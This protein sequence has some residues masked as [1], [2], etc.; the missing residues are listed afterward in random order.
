MTPTFKALAASTFL[1]FF[2]V[3]CDDAKKA[4]GA[5]DSGAEEGGGG[6]GEGL[7]YDVDDA[8]GDTI[9]DIHEGDE[10]TDGDGDANKND[11][12]SD[13]DS[14]KDRI[15]AGDGDP[16]TLPVDS[17]GDGNP[18]Y[19]DLD[20]DNNCVTDSDEKRPTGDGPVD[21]DLDGVRDYADEDNDGDGILDVDEIGGSCA[22]PDTDGDGTQDYMDLDSDGDGIGDLAEGGTTAFD[23]DP[24]DTDGDGVADYLDEDSD[25]DGVSDNAEGGGADVP[26]DTDGDGVPDFQDTDSDGDSISDYE[27]LN[28][29]GTDPYDADSDGDGFSDGG[30]LAAGT[31][32]LDSASVVEGVYVEVPERTNIEELF[33]FTLQVQLGDIA[34]LID[35]T[36]SMGSTANAMATEF[37]S[38]VSALTSTIPDAQYAVGTYDDYAYGGFGSAGSRDKP[39]YMLQQVTDD[40][41]TVQTTLSSRVQ[42]HGGSDGPESSMEALYQGATGEGY[43]QDCNRSYA[44]T[45]DVLPF[46]ASSTDPFGG[47]AG[48]HWV[49]SS[50][51]GGLNGGFGFRDY[52]LP[53]MVYATDYDLRD[54]DAGYGTPGGCPQ[55]AGKSD[56]VAAFADLQAYAIGIH[57]NS[58]T[59]TPYNQMLDLAAATGSYADT[60]GDGS[61]DDP[62][63][64]RWSG[65]SSTFRTTI[66]G[67]IEDLV[68]SIRFARVNLLIEGDEWG[69]VTGVS[70][71]YFTDID[72]AGGTQEIEF[73]LSFRGVVAAT[74]EDQLYRLSLTVVGDDS[75]LLDTLDII[76]LVP[77][78]SY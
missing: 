45:T 41:S 32:P 43:D 31:D 39:F 69:F 4:A 38:I 24:V 6:G 76:V 40:V 23:S 51:G 54:P 65:S 73:T 3:G 70:P 5:D 58:Y 46:L 8:D 68:S 50:S 29:T 44:S 71:E 9:I 14:I 78:N 36:C 61:S 60:D 34:F 63:A 26:R 19:L 15:E 74:T 48:Q 1:T 62:L 13:G 10:D 56:V 47:G 21:T 52:A 7:E 27:E 77:G 72:P 75:I 64:F 37:S 25:G 22:V 55:D 35:T 28:T 59:T 57:V 67:A 49:S 16:L 11:E 12:D 18:D 66:I 53:V 2:A 20:S 42:I 33:A 30:E 17:D